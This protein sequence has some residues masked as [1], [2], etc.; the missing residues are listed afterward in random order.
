MASVNTNDLRITNAKNLISSISDVGNTGLAYLFIG[1]S[2]AWSDGDESPHTPSNSISDFIQVYDEMLSLQRI[3]DGDVYHMI[4]RVSWTSGVIFDM[5][6]DDYSSTNPST[7]G[8]P[9]LFDSRWIVVNQNNDV[10][11]CLDN[12][13]GSI[14]TVEPIN[15]GDDAF[16]TSDNYQWLRVYTLTSA[17]LENI[18]NNLMPIVQ[19]DV[20]TTTDGEIYTVVIENGGSNYTSSPSGVVNQIPYY[21]CKINGDGTGA[22]SRVTVS[23][24]SITDIT[25]V[26]GGSGYTY[27]KIDFRANA[28]YKSLSD[29][30]SDTNALNPLGS[31]DFISSVVINPPGGWGTDIIK[32]LGGTRVGVS[33]NILSNTT[34]FLNNISF[35]Q[36]GIM[37]GALEQPTQSNPTTMNATYAVKLVTQNASVQ[38][39]QP[40]EIIYQLVTVGGETKKAKGIVVSWSGDDEINGILNYVQDPRVATDEDGGLY[41]F[42]GTNSII[43]ETNG[44]VGSVVD[45]DGT[46]DDRSFSNGYSTPEVQKYTG[47]LTYLSNISPVI[48]S[49]TQNE[50]VTLI[51]SY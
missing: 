43:G 23:N 26:R 45:Y 28:V 34:D 39:Y 4:P 22:A 12:N 7:S 3:D 42:G 11:I 21:Y 32:E 27:G 48:R 38:I 51:I 49:S 2:T 41:S 19:N 36:V 37:R 44:K 15:N 24:G 8:Q 35:R 20:V 5:Y 16:Y 6:R 47:Q 14:S 33:S 29:L 46:E 40:G 1:K 50:Q 17:A 30:D 31:G 18:T 13:G 25:V 10:Y 9:N